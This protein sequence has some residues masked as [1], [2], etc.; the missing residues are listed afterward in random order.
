MSRQ[1]NES[2][3]SSGKDHPLAGQEYVFVKVSIVDRSGRELPYVDHK[4]AISVKG[5]IELKGIGSGGSIA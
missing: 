5:D 3:H 1:R 2:I 4:L